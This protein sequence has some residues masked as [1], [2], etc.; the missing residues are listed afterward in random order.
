MVGYV[1]GGD[2]GSIGSL[3]SARDGFSHQTQL[4]LKQGE[5]QTANNKECESKEA[6]G[7]V[8]D[9]VPEGAVVWLGLPLITRFCAGFGFCWLTLR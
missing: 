9:P 3:W 2:L 8:R 6:G 1:L 5:R 7:V 4:P